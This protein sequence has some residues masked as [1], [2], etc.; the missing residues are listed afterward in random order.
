MGDTN[1]HGYFKLWR[2]FK[3]LTGISG[4]DSNVSNQCRKP[5]IK[6]CCA[7]V[8]NSSKIRTSPNNEDFAYGDYILASD[9]LRFVV[10]NIIPQKGINHDAAL[11]PASD[12]LPV[13]SILSARI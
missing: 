8:G 3:P 4:S 2:G 10:N 6:S 5:P 1:D 11:Y 9:N 13:L 7:P 12:H